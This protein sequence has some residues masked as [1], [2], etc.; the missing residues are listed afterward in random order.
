[1]SSFSVINSN[2]EP[3]AVNYVVVYDEA[4][5]QFFTHDLLK[6][7]LAGLNESFDVE[8]EI[9]VT[10]EFEINTENFTN[11]NLQGAD[12]VIIPSPNLGEDKTSNQTQ[13][14]Y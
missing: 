13:I 9:D 1:M 12:L 5:L 14:F 2:A 7:A 10:I 6:T 8:N 4:H 3:K 11:S